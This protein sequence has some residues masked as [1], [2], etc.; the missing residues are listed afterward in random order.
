MVKPVF[1]EETEG[2][3]HLKPPETA[4]Q[5]E[6]LVAEK[7]ARSRGALGRALRVGCGSKAR[8]A[9]GDPFLSLLKR[10]YTGTLQKRYP[11]SVLTAS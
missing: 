2:R 9:P 11:K 10:W 6:D 4:A 8:E 5:E 1:G 3:S 7:K